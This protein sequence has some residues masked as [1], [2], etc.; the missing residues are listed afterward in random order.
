MTVGS[1]FILLVVGIVALGGFTTFI[2][3]PMV[4]DLNA[5]T[6][7]VT[8][9]Q[10][11]SFAPTNETTNITISTSSS[12]LYTDPLGW[13]LD[14][15]NPTHFEANPVDN[16][17]AFVGE[18]VGKIA[19]IGGIILGIVSSVTGGNGGQAGAAFVVTFQV[20]LIKLWTDLSNPIQQIPI[21]GLFVV[22]IGVIV[23]LAVT[24]YA[25]AGML[26]GG[27]AY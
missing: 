2:L 21:L 26:S 8:S 25:Q 24:I 5:S 27:S 18:L 3:V 9:P 4:A 13:R 23:I 22:V 16:I 17:G 10:A 20:L 12:K 11:A 14:F 7:N 19:A 1:T 6:T 15:L